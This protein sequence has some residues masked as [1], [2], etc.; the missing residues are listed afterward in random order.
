ML[1]YRIE[2]I[3]H[4]RRQTIGKPDSR[5]VKLA[6]EFLIQVQDMLQ[7]GQR[8][9]DGIVQR[10]SFRWRLYGREPCS[11]SRSRSTVLRFQGLLIFGHAVLDGVPWGAVQRVQEAAETRTD[12]GQL[13]GIQ[14]GRQSLGWVSRTLRQ[15]RREI[16]VQGR[17]EGLAFGGPFIGQGI[18]LVST[19]LL[20]AHDASSLPAS[21]RC[22]PSVTKS[23]PSA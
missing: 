9:T 11:I 6:S 13:S 10:Y 5:E 19:P 22:R 18:E 15:V 2:S 3:F 14:R 4:L 20:C 17:E 21:C 8:L 1:T 23:S 16:G 12:G 7:D